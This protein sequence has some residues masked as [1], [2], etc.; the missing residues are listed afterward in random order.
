MTRGKPG[1][2]VGNGDILGLAAPVADH[3][4]PACLARHCDGGDGLGKRAY[5]V[6]LDENG[7]GSLLLYTQA[8]PLDVGDVQVVAHQLN[9]VPDGLCQ[10]SPPLQSSSAMPSSMLMMG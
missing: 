6:E 4:R 8:E 3:G 9:L 1:A 2:Q 5:L 7:I 10:E